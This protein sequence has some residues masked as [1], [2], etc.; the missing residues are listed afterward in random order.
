MK[1][2]CPLS[3]L[4][5]G[6]IKLFY[7]LKAP[8]IV[9]C[10]SH[11]KMYSNMSSIHVYINVHACTC[12]M[13]MCMTLHSFSLVQIAAYD[14]ITPILINGQ[15]PISPP[16]SKWPPADVNSQ[17][18]VGHPCKHHYNVHVLYLYY[19]FLQYMYMYLYYMYMY[20]CLLF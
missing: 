16:P 10:S 7:H 15:E 14:F 18:A 4:Q 12:T 2:T 13:Y 20:T 3:P 6:S 17:V 1:V 5:M 9:F 11:L 19:M 8:S